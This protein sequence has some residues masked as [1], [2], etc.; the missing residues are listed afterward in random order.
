MPNGFMGGKLLQVNLTDGKIVSQNIPQ[1]YLDKYI[2]GRALGAR[3]LYDNLPEGVA[4]LSPENIMFFMTGP[5]VGSGAPLSTRFIVVTK[6][7]LS[8][9]I[10]NSASG[11]DFGIKLKNAGY[12]ILMICG[13]SEKPVYLE[14]TDEFVAIRDAD[15]LWGKGT[16][17]TQEALPAKYGKAVIGPAGE[18]LVRFAAIVSGERVNARGGVG[19]VMGSKN[20][21][22]VIAKGS[23]KIELANPKGF[24]DYQKKYIKIFK[25]HPMQSDILPRLG[26]ANLV[27]KASAG[28]ILPTCNFKSG[29][30]PKAYEISGEKMAATDL[31]KKDGCLGC[32]IRCGRVV[33]LESKNNEAVKGPEYETLALFGS[34]QG[35]FNLKSI[36]EAN[37]ACD[38]LGLDTISAGNVIGF[39]M[40]LTEKGMLKSELAFGKSDNII[41]LLKDI[42]NRNGLGNELANGVKLLSEKYGGKEFA[43]HVKG[44]ELPGYDPR[45][46]WGQGLEYAVGNRGGDHV[47]GATMFLEVTGP[48]KVDPVTPTNK[49]HLVIMQQNTAAG[50]GSLIMCMFTSYA[51][52][53]SGAYKMNQNSLFY[54]ILTKLFLLMGP[55]LSAPPPPL[56][57]LWY[58][59]FMTHIL[60]RKFTF[61][62]FFFLGERAFNMERLFNLR[63]GLSA[64][65]DMLP[66]RLLKEPISKRLP[67]GVGL[68]KMIPAYYKTRG[69]DSEGRPTKKKLSQLGIDTA[70]RPIADEGETVPVSA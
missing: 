51:I 13:K 69:W 23:K 54:R 17:E 39:A 68:D 8:G 12:D 21:K 46:C 34:N 33:P 26:T 10:A 56:V 25:K 37:Y 11:G 42:A 2:G 49:H 70:L 47:Q 24:K 38:D 64:K 41:P 7:P 20:L 67:H 61:R 50:I 52:F 15:K 22:A 48:I 65:D 29:T 28:D 44:L 55:L 43:M 4:P 36:Y 14:I 5:M 63:E 16:Y 40:E 58:A 57:V 45:G 1:D 27:M 32:L 18:N 59:N 66:E 53:P 30:D 6:S 35:N 3:L 62:D 19:A 60:G 9:G 31:V